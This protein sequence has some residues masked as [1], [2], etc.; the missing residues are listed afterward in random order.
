MPDRRTEA[1][2]ALPEPYALGL[3]LRD[4]GAP[5]E[6]IADWLGVA[7]EALGPL[8]AVAEAKLDALLARPAPQA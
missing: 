3:R 6:V 7:P 2:R 1:M 5:D 4:A 8:L